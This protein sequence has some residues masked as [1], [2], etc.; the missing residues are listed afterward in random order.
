VI[1]AGIITVCIGAA[2]L[3]LPRVPFIGRLPGDISLRGDGYSLFIPIA[4]SIL[5]SIALTVVINIVIRL[6]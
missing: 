4:T 6:R 1:I 5:L 3:L 2:M